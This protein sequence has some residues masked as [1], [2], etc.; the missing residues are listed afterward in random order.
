MRLLAD[1]VFVAALAV[2]HQS[3]QVAHGPG[4][5]EE[6]RGEAQ[7]RR[8]FGL[9]AVD[10]GVLHIDVVAQ[11]AAAMA[12]RMPAVGWV[13]VLLRR[14]MT[15]TEGLPVR[16]KSLRSYGALPTATREVGKSSRLQRKRSAEGLG[17]DREEGRY[18]P[19]LGRHQDSGAQAVL[20]PRIG[21][22]DARADPPPPPSA[23]RR[24]PR[25]AG[26][27]ARVR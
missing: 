8:Q 2:G 10:R 7:A 26:S 20:H 17:H 11:L 25:P 24:Y 9:Q 16:R 12:S 4:R 19:E 15:G 22:D 18:I 27:P 23:C 3:E 13:T 1:D 6:R 14:S 5:Y 21:E